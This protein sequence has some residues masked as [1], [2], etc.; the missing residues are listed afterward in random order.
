MLNSRGFTY[1]AM[2][3]IAV[4]LGLAALRLHSKLGLVER[5]Q[6]QVQ[7]LQEAAE[8]VV[9]DAVERVVADAVGGMDGGELQGRAR[10]GRR[11]K[12]GVSSKR[13][14]P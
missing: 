9:E 6:A 3:A 10:G 13:S 4:G 7:A 2:G 14:E 5:R 1:V 8:G 11:G 12:D